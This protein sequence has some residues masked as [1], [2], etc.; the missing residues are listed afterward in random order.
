MTEEHTKTKR[1]FFAK[2]AVA[3]MMGFCNALGISYGKGGE[4][5]DKK[6][7]IGRMREPGEKD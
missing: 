7:P 5:Q 6:A 1:K 4:K 3:A 2:F